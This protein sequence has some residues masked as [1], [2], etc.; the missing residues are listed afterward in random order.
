MRLSFYALSLQLLRI[1]SINFH[2][3]SL[4]QPAVLDQSH[5]PL[6]VMCTEEDFAGTLLQNRVYHITGAFA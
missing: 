6:R 3:C 2:F 1:R 4:E 5:S